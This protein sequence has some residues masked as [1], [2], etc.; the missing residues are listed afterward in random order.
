MSTFW[1]I[2][3]IGVVAL[4]FIEPIG[5]LLI[6]RTETIYVCDCYKMQYHSG[7][8]VT[9]MYIIE[10]EEENAYLSEQEIANHSKV[11]ITYKG[12]NLPKLGLLRRIVKV[13]YIN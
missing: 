2:I 11:E 10:D 13:K 4:L 12:F 1:I 3:C 7:D 8:M 5:Y 9:R 6:R